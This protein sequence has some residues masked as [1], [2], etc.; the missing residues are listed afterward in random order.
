MESEIPAHTARNKKLLSTHEKSLYGLNFHNQNTYYSNKK[1][2]HIS[3]KYYIFS[4]ILTS[5]SKQTVFPPFK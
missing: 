2:C 5:H 4:E 3:L 1:T